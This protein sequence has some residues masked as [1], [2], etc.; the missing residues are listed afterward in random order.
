[1]HN[2]SREAI[3][4]VPYVLAAGAPNTHAERDWSLVE[5]RWIYLSNIKLASM[6]SESFSRTIHK[7]KL[8]H[9]IKI[10]QLGHLVT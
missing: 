5:S 2:A 6:I 4:G 9:V 3:L 10:K 1:M 8:L 7:Y